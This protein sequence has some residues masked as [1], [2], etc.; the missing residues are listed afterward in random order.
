MMSASFL[1]A[2]I[3]GGCLV[4]ASVDVVRGEILE[5][6]TADGASGVAPD[7]VLL[8]AIEMLRSAQR[9]SRLL[10]LTADHIHLYQR[11]ARVPHLATVVIA[12]RTT[13][14]G[15]LI[16]GLRTALREAEL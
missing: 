7:D 6:R 1:A 9:P 4:A 5:R 15:L 3:A 13:N 2:A 11:S 16:S 8:A 12:K 14:I 10:L